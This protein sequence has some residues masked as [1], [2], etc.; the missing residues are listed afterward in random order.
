MMDRQVKRLVLLLVACLLIALGLAWGVWYAFGRAPTYAFLGDMA[1]L[2]NDHQA[3]ADWYEKALKLRP[4]SANYHVGLSGALIKMHQGAEAIEHCEEAARLDPKSHDVPYTHSRALSELDDHEGAIAKLEE[5]KDLAQQAG[6]SQWQIDHLDEMIDLER[7]LLVITGTNEQRERLLA[8]LEEETA[9][10]EA[11]AASM[12][13]E[14]EQFDEAIRE[15][16][17][18]FA[19]IGDMHEE[20]GKRGKAI[21]AWK[22]GAEYGDPTCIERLKALGIEPPEPE[23][24][25]G[26]REQ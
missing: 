21:D 1:D 15:A 6:V 19:S 23:A 5:A 20:N 3:A 4:D 24:A 12:E 14:V 25:S 2:R 11:E 18:S 22:T 9:R 17:A 13:Q 8:K 10:L 16:A 7:Q 26:E